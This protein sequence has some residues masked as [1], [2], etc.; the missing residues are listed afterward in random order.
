MSRTLFLRCNKSKKDRIDVIL[1]GASL[2]LKLTLT[3]SISIYGG[4]SSQHRAAKIVESRPPLN[5][6]NTEVCCSSN[7]IEP[8]RFSIALQKRLWIYFNTLSSSTSGWL[9]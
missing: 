4:S 1:S 3:R 7:G 8:V 2:G 5:I 9:K 6:T